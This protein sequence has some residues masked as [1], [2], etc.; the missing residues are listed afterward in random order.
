VKPSKP[1]Y[2]LLVLVFTAVTLY[3]VWVL[4]HGQTSHP[5]VISLCAVASSLAVVLGVFALC[6][7]RPIVLLDDQGV[8]VRGWK[9]CPV[10]WS[11]IERAWTHQQRIQTGADPVKV[12]Y[13]CM[14][15]KSGSHFGDGQ[16]KL[17]GWAANHFKASGYGDL[18][19]PAKGM[20]FSADELVA[21]IQSHIGGTHLSAPASL[22]REGLA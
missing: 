1:K 2:A 12:E 14:A 18:Y 11:D 6:D 20:D 21:A 9:N 16:G 22:V 17:K 4:V 8:T 7:K 3:L 19:F 5:W 10:P 15:I 13:V